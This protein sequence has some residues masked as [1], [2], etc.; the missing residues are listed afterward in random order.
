MVTSMMVNFLLMCITLVFIGK[1][2]PGIAKRIGVLKN[3]TMQL[4]IGWMGIVSLSAFLT[5]HTYKDMTADT[6][7]WYFHSTPIWLIVMGVA[8]AIF[9][10]NWVRL[11]KN[12]PDLKK[13]FL[14][15]PEE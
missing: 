7:A 4:L 13:R 12:E 2:N 11:T 8:S 1:L 9:V 3:R 15:L 5:I 10:Y 14:Q 6:T